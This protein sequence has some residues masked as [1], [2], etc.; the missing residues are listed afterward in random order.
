MTPYILYGLRRE[1]EEIRYIG[2]TSCLETRLSQHLNDRRQ[3]N[4]R[5][6][7]MVA[8]KREGVP[9]RIVPF[10]ILH[11]KDDASR[12][13]IAVIAALK[14]LDFRLVNGTPG[15]DGLGKGSEH[16]HFGKKMPREAV[17]KSAAAHR[18]KKKSAEARQKMSLA[19]RGKKKSLEWRQK[20]RKPKSLATRAKMSAW[21][22][23]RKLSP[24]TKAKQSESKKRLWV[25]RGLPP[26]IR[27]NI[28]AGQRRRHQRGQLTLPLDI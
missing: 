28:S 6:N 26:E 22:I 1:D 3:P 19:R 2:I 24:E 12:L 14:E 18:G 4:H 23:G 15:G 9:I 8:A 27:A 13:E 10:C 25:S 17:E 16:P 21:Q 20:M 7:W 11:C 5:I